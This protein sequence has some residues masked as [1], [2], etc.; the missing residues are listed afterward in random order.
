MLAITDYDSDDDYVNYEADSNVDYGDSDVD[1][2][3]ILMVVLIMMSTMRLIFTL[4]VD[5][6]ALSLHN[7]ITTHSIT[8]Y[9]PLS[10]HSITQ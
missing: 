7:T 8:T 10:S 3:D 9:Q 5:V 6:S 1:T 2:N 4:N